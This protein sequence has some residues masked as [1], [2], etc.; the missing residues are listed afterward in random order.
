M[1]A[2][3]EICL[4]NE[5][6]YFVARWHL[7]VR[8]W[9]WLLFDCL[10]RQTK[11]GVERLMKAHYNLG[12]DFFE[13]II[14]P[15][16][17]YSCG[18]WR[19]ASN[20]DEA[21]RDKMDLIAKKLKLQPGMTVLDIGC[22]WGSL[23]NYLSNNYDVHVTG[24]TPSIEGVKYIREKFHDNDKLDVLC[25]GYRD[26]KCLG[27]F[28]RVVSIAAFEHFGHRNYRTFFQVCRERLKE[29]GILLLQ[30]IGGNQSKSYYPRFERY[31]DKHFFPGAELPYKSDLVN[32]IKHLF[33]VEDWHNFGADYWK[34]GIAWIQNLQ[35]HK[36]YIVDKYG[37][38][39]YQTFF[40]TFNMMI[41]FHYRRI[42]LWQ[43]VLTKNGLIG[44]Y[45][46]IR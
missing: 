38:Q 4:R 11:A 5:Y 18:Y 20:L 36:D 24:V 31:A 7:I 42:H 46:S 14:G 30:T 17:Q 1:S 28:D 45:D 3:L 10:N 19:K 21:Q 29:E 23:A 13:K 32:A 43:I 33:V 35:R 25:G 8:F 40:V 39:I 15:T 26:L 44:G 2:I 12:N 16:M 41:N 34:T 6:D 9:N 22:G 37:F 27:T